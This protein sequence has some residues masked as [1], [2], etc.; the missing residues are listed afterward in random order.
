MSRE[1]RESVRRHILPVGA[2]PLRWTHA[3]EGE[4]TRGAWMKIK[5]Q[6]MAC[7]GSYTC[8]EHVKTKEMVDR[9]CKRRDIA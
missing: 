3:K 6:C 5:S 4:V 7:V 8:P 9:Y 1:Q 2:P